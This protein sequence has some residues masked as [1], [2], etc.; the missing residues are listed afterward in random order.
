MASKP[1]RAADALAKIRVALIEWNDAVA[2]ANWSDWDEA[3]GIH[4][5]FSLGAVVVDSAQSVTLAGTWGIGGDGIL[6]TNNCMTIP[7]GMILK[8]R[9]V[10]I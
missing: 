2:D 8:R 7:A 3:R 9:F 1:K 6:Q 10:K 4:R 5:C